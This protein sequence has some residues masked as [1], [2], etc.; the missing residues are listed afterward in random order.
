[1][2]VFPFREPFALRQVLDYASA[3]ALFRWSVVVSAIS[4]MFPRARQKVAPQRTQSKTP[5]APGGGATQ[6]GATVAVEDY[7]PNPEGL[8]LNSRG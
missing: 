8:N 2:Q 1:M 5:G 3:L 7:S 6:F 4:L